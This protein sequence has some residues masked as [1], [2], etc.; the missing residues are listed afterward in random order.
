MSGNLNYCLIIIFLNMITF[1]ESKMIAIPFKTVKDTDTNYIKSLLQYQLYTEMEIGDPKQKVILAISTDTS[2]FN[3]ESYLLNET[4]Y[5]PNKSTSYRNNSYLYKVFEG[6]RIKIAEILNDTFYFKDSM[7]S[8]YSIYQNITFNYIIQLSTGSSGKDNG[9]IDNNSNLISGVIGFQITREYNEV[10]HVIF[11]KSLKRITEIDKIIWHINY[12]NDNEGYLI[13]GEYPHQYNNSYKENNLKKIHCIT[14]SNDYYWYFIFTDIRVGQIKMIK[15]R[16]ADYA[17]QIGVILGT[18]EYGKAV[19]E[20]F[21]NKDKCSYNEIEFKKQ[22]YFY[23]EC[24]NNTNIDDFEPIVFIHQELEYNFTLDKN[25]LFIDFN[26]KKYFLVV[27]KKEYYEERWILGKP[28]VKKYQFVFDY[29]A[30]IIQFYDNKNGQN[31]NENQKNGN[32]IL[33]YILLVILGFI[34]LS[35]GI[36]IGNKFFGKK[37]KKKANELEDSINDVGNQNSININNNED[38]PNSDYNKMGI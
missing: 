22:K 12:I 17:P 10:N 24:D 37:K 27:F 5:S 33:L 23:Y 15:Y 2:F 25:D 6:E 11:I 26:N 14:F 7:N 31:I 34:V 4:F 3:I 35:L 1:K 32:Q 18:S 36:Y 19:K 21:G 8:N 9:Y 28:F 20:F 16:M 38:S 13:F 29:D 30:K